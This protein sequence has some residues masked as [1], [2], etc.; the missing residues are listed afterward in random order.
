[1]K[2][3]TAIMLLLFVSMTFGIGINSVKAATVTEGYIAS[4]PKGDETQTN[5]ITASKNYM[6]AYNY[7][8]SNSGGAAVHTSL[9]AYYNSGTYRVGSSVKVKSGKTGTVVWEPSS[10]TYCPT[11]T[12]L[13]TMKTCNTSG[14]SNSSYCVL[15]NGSYFIKLD[16]ENLFS[17]FNVSGTY[18][19]IS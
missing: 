4:V 5:P 2:K 17:A 12:S 18:G 13:L 1:M 14:A 9:W 15:K 11:V 3:I 8:Q 7:I 16:N 6:F 10:S 19:F